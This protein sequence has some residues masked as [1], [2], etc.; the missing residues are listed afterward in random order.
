MCEK[1]AKNIL[2]KFERGIATS[3]I[4]V[5]RINSLCDTRLFAI[6]AVEIVRRLQR[7]TPII[8]NMK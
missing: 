6:V 4:F 2:P 3:G 5:L 1:Y 8:T 7:P